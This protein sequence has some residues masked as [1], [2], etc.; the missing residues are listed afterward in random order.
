MPRS[1]SAQETVT[2]PSNASS[3]GSPDASGDDLDRA[4]VDEV[5]R[6]RPD[7][8]LEDARLDRVRERA[9]VEPELADRDAEGDALRLARRRASTRAKLFSSSTGRVTTRVAVADV[10]LDD[11]VAAPVAGV[12]DRDGSTVIDSLHATAVSA[13]GRRR[14]ARTSCSSA[15]SRTGRA[16]S[17]GEST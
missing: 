12:G 11:L 3:G 13:S 15:R 10:Q 2:I 4:G 8:E 6:R 5:L 1:S 7:E 16:G 17:A 14:R 9:I